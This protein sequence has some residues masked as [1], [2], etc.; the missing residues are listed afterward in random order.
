MSEVMAEIREMLLSITSLIDE[1][2][3]TIN[4]SKK[5]G[6]IHDVGKAAKEASDFYHIVKE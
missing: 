5:S 1:L 6:L 2:K 3:L 4:A